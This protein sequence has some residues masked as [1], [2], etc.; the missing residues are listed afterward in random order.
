MD[1]YFNRQPGFTRWVVGFG[2]IE[3][4]FVVIDGGCQGGAHPRWEALGDCLDYHGFDPIEEVVEDLKSRSRGAGNRS[5][6][7]LALGAADGETDFFFSPDRPFESALFKSGRPREETRRVAVRSL[8]S[9]FLEGRIPSADFLKLDC[10][11]FEPEILRGADSFIPQAGVLGVETETGLKPT[12][13]AP[14]GGLLV[15]Y[16]RLASH[17][18]QLVDLAFDRRMGAQAYRW[19]G[20]DGMDGAGRYV[21]GAPSTVN[22]LFSRAPTVGQDSQDTNTGGTTRTAPLSPQNLI[23]LA[24]ILEL[25][26]LPDLAMQV[27]TEGADTLGSVLD[28]DA[29]QELL[30]DQLRGALDVDRQSRPLTRHL[31]ENHVN[32]RTLTE[33]MANFQSRLGHF[34]TESGALVAEMGQRLVLSERL[35]SRPDLAD[36]GLS[37]ALSD[38]TTPND[39]LRFRLRELDAVYKSTSWKVTWP[40][41][42]LGDRFRRWRS[43]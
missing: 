41:R 33:A 17:G 12:R 29:A 25:Y 10:E 40:L 7:A 16:Q 2:L 6:H 37:E 39:E 24:V 8:D 14:G 42:L 15:I 26:G 30:G 22:A 36:S 5:F 1:L 13:V 38:L 23:K 32:G 4:P 35:A 18:I 21:G 11:G 3:E 27:L 43:R 19:L 20:D 31:S 28:L 34:D 9:L